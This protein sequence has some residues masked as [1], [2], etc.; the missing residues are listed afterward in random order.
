MLLIKCLLAFCCF[1][2]PFKC[3]VIPNDEIENLNVFDMLQYVNF[4][5]PSTLIEESAWNVFEM[6]AYLDY[7]EPSML[8]ERPLSLDFDYEFEPES[9]DEEFYEDFNSSVTTS[10]E[11][12]LT[13]RTLSETLNELE[14]RKEI[15][16]FVDDLLLKKYKE[17]VGDM[18]A[19]EVDWSKISLVEWPKELKSLSLNTK[20]YAK[21]Q[22]VLLVQNID[23]VQFKVRRPVFNCKRKFDGN[24]ELNKLIYSEL[25]TAC[26]EFGWARIKW[27]KLLR[28]APQLELSSLC[29]LDWCSNDRA[30]IRKFILN[31]CIPTLNKS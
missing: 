29:H 24:L 12:S 6:L 25:K 4:P 16:A 2:L 13:T 1:T 3:A 18:D 9:K 28:A 21:D 19:T 7:P 26:K 11:S 20:V 23:K 5:E 17:V 10:T 14:S 27:G 31:G 15:L 22:C 8:T 30:S